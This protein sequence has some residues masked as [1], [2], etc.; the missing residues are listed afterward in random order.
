[1]TEKSLEDHDL[2]ARTYHIRHMRLIKELTET[3]IAWDKFR[4]SWKGRIPPEFLVDEAP[5]LHK[6][7]SLYGE[8]KECMESITKNQHDLSTIT[9]EYID[10]QQHQIKALERINEINEEVIKHLKTNS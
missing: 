5:M 7:I 4:I 2:A 3:I 9:L 8:F 1:M 6:F 10:N